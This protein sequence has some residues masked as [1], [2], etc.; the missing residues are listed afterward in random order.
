M[1]IDG[2]FAGPIGQEV[3]RSPEG[4]FLVTGRITFDDAFS[5]WCELIR[6]ERLRRSYA[7]Q[8]HL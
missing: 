7:K 3:L 2:G 5:A 8:D 1:S 4:Q 6:R